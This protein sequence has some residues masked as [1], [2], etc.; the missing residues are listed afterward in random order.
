MIKSGWEFQ[1]ERNLVPLSEKEIENL[2]KA[3]NL[4]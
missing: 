1:S 2:M 4:F 3:K